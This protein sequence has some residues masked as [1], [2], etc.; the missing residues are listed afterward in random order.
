[1]ADER[2][3]LCANLAALRQTDAAFA[4]RIEQTPAAS[5]TWSESRAGPLT[6]TLEHNGRTLALA[7]RYDP[8][9][10]AQKLIAG[11]DAEQ[12][13]CV[14]LLGLGLG[15][16]AEAALAALGRQ[17]LLVV[18]EPDTALWRAVLERIDHSAWLGRANVIVG[19]AALDRP[20]LTRRLEPHAGTVTQGTKLVTH[21]PSRQRHGEAFAAFS[22]VVTETLAYCRTNVATA[23]VNAA[24]TCSNTTGNLVHY[25]A[26]PTTDDLI[27]AASGTPAVCVGAGPSL[28]R[29]VDLLRDP[30]IRRNVV[31]ITAQ[32]TLKPLLERG[33]RPDFVTSLDY[34]PISQRFYEDLPPL[35]RV[36]LVAEPKAH[37]SILDAFPG[38]I[39]LTHNGFCDKVLGA[40]ARPR[41]PIRP[42][43][44][45]AHLSFYL[46][47][48]LGCDPIIL[49]GQDLGFCD[50]LYYAPG[51]PIHRVW[52]PELNA[53][54]TLEMM[55]WT[56]IA[57][58][59]VHLQR[60]EDVHGRPMYSDEQMITYLRQFERDFANATQT[61]IDAT[62][63]GAPKAGVTV[64]PLAEALR[65]Y[66][67]RPAPHLPAPKRTLDPAR[68]R[69]TG[70]IIDRRLGQIEQIREA[71]RASIPILRKMQKRRGDERAMAKL[72]ERLEKHKKRVEGELAEAFTIVNQLNLLGTYKRNRAD[73]AIELRCRDDANRR[74]SEQIERDLVNM[75]L[76]VEACDE[77]LV[78]FREAQRRAEKIE[79]EA[80]R[81]ANATPTGADGADDADDATSATEPAETVEPV[82]AQTGEPRND[83]SHV[84]TV[85]DLSAE[86]LRSVRETVQWVRQNPPKRPGD[87]RGEPTGHVAGSAGG[88]RGGET[89]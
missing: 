12:T 47:Q 74:Q 24:R 16:A 2:A 55:E 23:L 82:A 30:A 29:N 18:Y 86:I 43:A 13:A 72:F 73:R 10:E 53:F 26:G 80:Q 75:D 66:A 79:R 61:V 58:H 71:A 19:D 62:E 60:L 1:M 7:S 87:A 42:G 32:T 22:K 48:H 69:E 88:A 39:R 3:I 76:L 21:P 68:A 38:P 49:I 65:R 89:P 84:E 50:G 4:Q 59:K 5:L 67:T 45:V 31:V 83:A 20:A 9:G 44:T 35:P 51:N 54:N 17:G 64:M 6:A 25:H 40:A 77:A 27:G 52:A 81:Q 37:P 14:V 36:T 15:Y 28:V 34:S 33:I 41:R 46:A 8:R 63:G 57:R 70:R 85:E 11:I 56:R 78:I